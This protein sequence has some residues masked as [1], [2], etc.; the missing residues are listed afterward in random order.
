MTCNG[1]ACHM[2]NDAVLLMFCGCCFSAFLV[3]LALCLATSG[4]DSN[5]GWC[6]VTQ[7][8]IELFFD[9]LKN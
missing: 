5:N 8:F 3:A 4:G 6:L 7:F 1:D 9:M 2:S